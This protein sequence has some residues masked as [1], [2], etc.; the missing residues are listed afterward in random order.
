VLFRSRKL[1]DGEAAVARYLADYG[2]LRR[3]AAADLARLRAGR[4]ESRPAGTGGTSDTAGAAAADEPA[5]AFFETVDAE[6]K[7]MAGDFK[8]EASTA[9]RRGEHLVVDVSFNGKVTAPLVVDTGASQTVISPKVAAELGLQGGQAVESSVADGRVV[10]GRLFLVDSLA[11]GKARV[12]KTPVIV[13]GAP[14]P[15]A[16]GLLGMSFLKNFMFQL[17]MPNNRLILEGLKPAG[18]KP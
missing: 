12:D 5:R 4:K 13:M 9:R 14:G 18:P 10:Q 7:A 1:E 11:V 8:R 6:L 3:S 17:D 15:E 16:E 2:A